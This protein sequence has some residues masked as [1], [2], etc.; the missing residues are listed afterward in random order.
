MIT[1]AEAE[2][3]ESVPERVGIRSFSFGVGVIEGG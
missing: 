3:S 2:A 1:D